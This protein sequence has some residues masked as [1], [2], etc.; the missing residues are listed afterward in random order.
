MADELVVDYSLDFSGGQDASKKPS[1]TP[2]N[3]YYAGVNVSTKNGVLSPRSPLIQRQLTYPEGGVTQLNLQVR[4]YQKIFEEGRFQA[5]IPYSIGRD[6]YRI[7]V[8][9]GVIFLMNTN[10]FVLKVI[11]IAGG[12]RINETHMRVESS[13]AGRFLVIFD[14]PNFPVIIENG[15]AR[16]ADPAKNEVPISVLGAYN[17]NR[18]FIANAGNEFTAGDAS[19]NLAA[20]DAPITFN[21]IIL[22]N[23]GYTG[24]IFQL[25]TNYNNDPITAMTFLQLT[26]VST[27]IGPLIVSTRNIV[28]S[29]LTNQPRAN[30]KPD[31]FGSAF[32][33]N[34]GIVGPRAFTHVNS[35]F[36][37]LSP[38]GQIRS[39]AMSRDEQKKWSKMPLSREVQN[40][41]K[42]SDET[43]MQY[44][45][46]EYFDNK[47]IATCNPYHT[48]ARTLNGFP[49]LDVAHGGFVVLEFDNISVLGS[50]AKPSWAGLW[51][52]VRPMSISVSDQRCFIV[53]KDYDSINRVYELQKGNGHDLVNNRRRNVKSLVYTRMFDF[54]D[55]FQNKEIHS[56]DLTPEDVQG[57]LKLDIHY[58]PAQDSSFSYWRTFE[59]TAP[60]ETCTIPDSQQGNGLASHSFRELN[61]GSPEQQDCNPVT[62]VESS[63]FR[64]LQARFTIQAEYWEISEF[65]LK[66]LKRAQ[67]EQ[68]SEMQCTKYPTVELPKECDIDWVIED[69][70][71][72][73][74]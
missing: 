27:G 33:A 31:N 32:V 58:R 47:V 72:C 29:Y 39:A 59:H 68:I 30:W 16:R 48:V 15:V 50:D 52:G 36:Y 57:D 17:Q 20:P 55:P 38:D 69:E 41:L 4:S 40:W 1:K 67:S 66:A 37:Y 61:I 8:I 10:T 60:F 63:Y 24:Q 23:T 2:K 73:P 46:M 62:R 18:L 14:Y 28:Y 11:D 51:T 7:Y 26:D 74:T 3:A 44:S 42:F 65:K 34:S 71:L 25:G 6:N 12:S 45:V 35:D 53:S 9:S 22:P 19:G 54:Q 21:E 49:T 43:L 5:D 70:S 56:M 64:R 13:P